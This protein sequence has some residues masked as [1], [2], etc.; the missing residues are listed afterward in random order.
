MNRGVLGWMAMSGGTTM[1]ELQTLV[2]ASTLARDL[3]PAEVDAM[4]LDARTFNA[5][6]EVTGVLLQGAGKFFQVI[7]GAEAALDDVFRRIEAARAHRDIRILLR[8]PL[9]ERNFASWYMGFAAAPQTAIQELSQF[10]WEEAIPLTRD[11]FETPQGL[12]LALEHWSRW[13]ASESASLVA[14]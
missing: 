14:R 6:V 1:S 10:A 11:T 9:R 12:A 3:G 7:E 5:S 13:S 4:L 2:Y 8:K